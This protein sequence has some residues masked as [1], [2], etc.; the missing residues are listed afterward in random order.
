VKKARKLMK[1]MG[2]LVVFFFLVFDFDR[3]AIG[4]CGP[5]IQ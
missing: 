4:A 2:F 5:P 1:T 3:T